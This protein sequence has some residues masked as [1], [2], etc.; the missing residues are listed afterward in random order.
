M[1][2]LTVLLTFLFL[3]AVAVAGCGNSES[4]SS[5]DSIAP[6]GAVMYGEMTLAPDGDQKEAIDTIVSRFP[7]EGS[8]G[9]RIR[10]L[11][12]DALAESDT[13][14]SYKNDVEPWLGDEAGFFVSEP[15]RDGQ[16]QS[17]AVMIAADDED[18]A[19]ETLEKAV[20][21]DSRERSYKDVDYLV[22]TTNDT[23]GGV[24]D[25]FLVLGNE[26]ALKSAI[27]TADGGSPLADDDTFKDATGDMADNRLGFVYLNSPRLFEATS[28][29]AGGDVIGAF[30]DLFKEPYVTTIAA[31]RD[32]VVFE[33]N[34]P[35]SLSKVVPFLGEGSDLIDELPGDSWLALAQPD[36]GKLADFYID[37]FGA[38][39]GGRDVIEEQLRA[40]T[41]LDLQSDVLDWM[42]DFG[43]FV[44]GTSVAELNGA[45][46]VETSDPAATER[47]LGRLAQ[48]ARAQ[49]G[50]GTTIGPLSASGGGEGFTVR[51]DEL[52]QPV[53]VF[54]R[55]DRFVI[56][57]GDAAAEDAVDPAERLADSQA[58]SDAAG[59]LDGYDT[60]FFLDMASVLSLVEST[61]HSSDPTWA[62]V[63]PYLE[64]L[65]SLVGWSKG[66]GDEI[67]QAF[68]IVIE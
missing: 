13:P 49:Q 21:G 53:H 7:G 18:A 30:R 6:S 19:R 3:S 2:A 55:D 68:K 11:V 9:E 45:V 23:A 62:Q 35:E 43:V 63:K 46:V 57:Y 22:A 24:V 40:Q 32:G 10:A 8:A 20:K 38:A 33:G 66:E 36:L 34:A 61:E 47:L 64:P 25:G 59:S 39:A 37:A 60:S 14:L 16:F 52:P 51:D 5:A 1:R 15:G 65:R 4:A 12:E 58:F 48:L 28:Q 50:S 67:S 56:A 31:E 54:L 44:R 26:R 27:D 42:G 29:T 41:G 17:G